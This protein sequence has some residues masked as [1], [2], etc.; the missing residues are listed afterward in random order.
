MS[1]PSSEER[2]H[3]FPANSRAFSAEKVRIVFIPCTRDAISQPH[4]TMWIDSGRRHFPNRKQECLL[5][6]ENTKKDNLVWVGKM[7]VCCRKPSCFWFILLWPPA[8]DFPW[9][10]SP[11]RSLLTDLFKDDCSH[12]LS[13]FPFVAFRLEFSTLP[14]TEMAPLRHHLL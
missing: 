5:S 8:P 2:K 14:L 6:K 11:P 10:G 13:E 1:P 12:P 9:P 7:N 4:L 3:P